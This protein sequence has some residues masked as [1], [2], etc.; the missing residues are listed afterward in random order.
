MITEKS[1]LRREFPPEV[2][3]AAQVAAAHPSLPDRDLLDVEFVTIDPEESTDL[4]QAIHIAEEADGFRVRYA[5]ADVPS[6][7]APS[8]P[9]DVEARKRGQTIYAPDGRIPLHPT[10]ISENAGSLLPGHERGAY[11]WDLRL[12][13]AGRV[14]AASVARARV[15]SRAKLSYIGVQTE[16]DA[17]TADPM[18]HLLKKVGILRAELEQERG[19]AS[20]NI[21][22]IEI[23]NDRDGYRLVRRSPLEVEGWN[24]QISLMTGMVAARMML[25]AKI[26]IVRTMPAPEPTAIEE[27]RAQTIALDY[28]W[29]EGEGYGAY[30]RRL[31]AR[32]PKQLAIMYAAASLFRG[33]G[34]TAFD[35]DVPENPI[36]AAVAAPYAHTTAPLRRLVDRFV[37]VCCDSLSNGRDVPGW[38][39]DALPQLPALMDASSNSSGAVS[40]A[41]IDTVEAAVLG[42]HIGET[43]DAVVISASNGGNGRI[44]LNE[45]AVTA[46]CSG[47]LTVGEPVRATLTIADI[48]SGTVAFEAVSS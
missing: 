45:P 21:P 10:V 12:D 32:Q 11:V 40:R 48:A 43:F 38:V 35:G 5:I 1:E 13:A 41:A 6:F 39:R 29:A 42:P 24:A 18:L 26:G 34:Y 47:K 16:M 14:T 27:F 20:L 44:Q 23:E 30:L 9:I 36:Q 46:S 2:E 17:G 19:G 33:A 28:P 8:G 22:D 3:A 15:R 31:D 25:D 4:D 7:V 37:L